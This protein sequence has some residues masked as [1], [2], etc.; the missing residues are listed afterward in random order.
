M[1]VKKR[2]KFSVDC[3]VDCSCLRNWPIESMHRI[4]IQIYIF[5]HVCVI[6]S[7]KTGRLVIVETQF[8]TMTLFFSHCVR[9]NSCHRHI[10]LYL[11][12]IQLLKEKKNGAHFKILAKKASK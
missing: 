1:F 2:N 10:N 7:N 6:I 9:H 3:Y 4:D 8:H 12:S 11:N 5:F